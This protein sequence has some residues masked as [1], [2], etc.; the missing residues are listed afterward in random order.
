MELL[1]NII[2]IAN[3][4]GFRAKQLL[5]VNSGVYVPCIASEPYGRVIFRNAYSLLTNLLNDVTFKLSKGDRA[6]FARFQMLVN[7][8]GQI[9]LNNLFEIG[10]VVIGFDGVQYRLLSANEYDK[11]T[12][13]NAEFVKPKNPAIKIQVIESDIY[14]EKSIS[15]A[16]F[17]KPYIHF[18]DLAF[19]GS[20]TLSERLGTLVI[21]SPKNLNNAPTE[22]ILPKSIKEELEQQIAA[23]YGN[24]KQQKQIMLLPREMAWQVINLAGYDNHTSDKVLL[25]AKVIADTLQI[26]ANQIALIDASSSKALANGSEL[27]EG[28]RMK[29]ST[30][31]R[32]LNATF[33]NFAQNIG[34]QIDYTIYNKPTTTNI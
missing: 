5:N 27:R 31:E 18:L 1:N 30:F 15:Y 8:D 10:F 25:C 22:T 34:L 26:P 21:G 4:L 29:Y 7:R 11:E 33:V 23:D 28:D 2:K 24:L 12:T 20:A 13:A 17:L 19:N 32:L 16:Q 14:R 3:A 9:I 6:N